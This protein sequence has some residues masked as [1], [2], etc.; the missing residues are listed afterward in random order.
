MRMLILTRRSGES[1]LIGNEIAVTVLGRQGGHV[2]LGIVAPRRVRV[3][4][5]ELSGDPLPPQRAQAIADTED[6]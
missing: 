1:I 2:R 4:R 6:E 3:L 5:S